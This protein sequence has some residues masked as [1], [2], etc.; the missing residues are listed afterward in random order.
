MS[1]YIDADE[2]L[3]MMRNSKQ[4]N[5]CDV[6]SKGIWNIAHDCCISCLDAVPT[7]DVVEVVRCKDCKHCHHRTI[8]NN[9]RYECE[10]YGCSDE[11][12]DYVEPTHYCSYGERREE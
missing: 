3:R 10:Y 7:A 9:E 4:D 2:A 12:V 1:R 5:P 6:P 11:V 8:P